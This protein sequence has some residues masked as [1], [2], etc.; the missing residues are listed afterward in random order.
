MRQTIL[1]RVSFLAG[2]LVLSGSVHAQDA[3]PPPDA[4]L[5]APGNATLEP[6][7][8]P[9]AVP[10]MDSDKKTDAMPAQ[11]QAARNGVNGASGN[12]ADPCPAPEAALNQT[13]DDLAKVQ[14]DI[15][16]FT[17]CVQRAQLF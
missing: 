5:Q 14:A 12:N 13:P 6:S 1:T 2:I 9:A 7:L 8:N 10:V 17:L 11:P 15:D 16:R 3:A 4:Q